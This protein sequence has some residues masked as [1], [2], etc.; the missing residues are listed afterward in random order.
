MERVKPERAWWALESLADG[1]Y[2]E[3][4]TTAQRTA[5]GRARVLSVGP[6]F[7]GSSVLV[8]SG[9]EVVP[10]AVVVYRGYLEGANVPYPL[11]YPDVCFIHGD[12]IIGVME[13]ELPEFNADD[14]DGVLALMDD[15]VSIGLADT[16][17][18]GPRIVTSLSARPAGQ[19]L[20]SAKGGVELIKEIARKG[21]R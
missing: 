16:D 11:R 1:A 12:S 21:G 15:D 20:F 13:E 18:D 7:S 5:W 3:D 9:G 8:G 4:G 19:A 10:G 2:Y 17:D 14:D 6:R